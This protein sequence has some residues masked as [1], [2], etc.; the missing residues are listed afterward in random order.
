MVQHD[1]QV[2]VAYVR[3]GT[4]RPNLGSAHGAMRLHQPDMH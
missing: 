4:L 3:I 2:L 1:A